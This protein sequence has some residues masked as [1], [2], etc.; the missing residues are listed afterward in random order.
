MV[1]KNLLIV[2]DSPANLKLLRLLLAAEGHSVQTADC[3]AKAL[4]ILSSFT[5]DVIFMDIQM[6]EVNGLQLTRL[7]KGRSQTKDIMVI[8]ISANAMKIDIAEAYA[9]GCEGY[10]T[11][12]ID[13]R[14]FVSTVNEYLQCLET[15]SSG[16]LVAV[17][18]EVALE[19]RGKA[20]IADCSEQIDR[21]LTGV[22]PGRH[23]I[24]EVLHRCEGVARSLGRPSISLVSR[25]P[26]RA[27]SDEELRTELLNLRQRFAKGGS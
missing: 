1:T 22:T 19:G 20:L 16:D 7:L 23:D 15:R 27:L 26:E 3:A 13:T 25:E 4:E 6:A 12:P 14:T 2:D 10:I 24:S 21:V 9:A 5:P 11:K 18:K 8:A 17:K